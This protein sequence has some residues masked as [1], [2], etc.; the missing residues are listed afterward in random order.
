MPSRAVYRATGKLQMKAEELREALNRA[1]PDARE[2]GNAETV[3]RW[4]RQGYPGLGAPDLVED[5]P[6]DFGEGR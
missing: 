2:I 4:V 1:A 3:R 5:E 6:L